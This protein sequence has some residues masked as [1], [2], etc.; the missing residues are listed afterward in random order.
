MKDRQDNNFIDFLNARLKEPLPGFEAHQH[1]IR[2]KEGKPFR[3][4]EPEGDTH[5][6]AVLVILHGNQDDLSLLFTLRSRNLHKHSGQISFPGGR[7][8][9]GETIIETALREA[10]EEIGLNPEIV[11]IIGELSQLFVPPSKSIIYPVISYVNRL[12]ELHPNDGEVD[13][14]FSIPLEFFG[15]KE[16]LQL[17]EMEIQ[18]N[19]L[20]VPYWNI[21]PDVP[22]WGATA[23]ILSE[24][25][26]LYE[27]Y[28]KSPYSS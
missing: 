16:N 9:N 13:E 8:E 4:Y 10:N 25:V 1:M 26:M 12:N 22:L 15:N 5:K 14:I 27:E 18:G 24:L 23:M 3:R 2:T 7:T 20:N 28:N 17:K 6:S 11:N 21:H 19:L